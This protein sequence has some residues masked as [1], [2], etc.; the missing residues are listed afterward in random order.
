MFD[1][2]WS[3]TERESKAELPNCLLQLLCL[4]LWSSRG[5][6]TS[7]H[8]IR[9]SSSCLEPS[10]HH[11]S[12]KKLQ[13]FC[14][15]QPSSS[16]LESSREIIIHGFGSWNWTHLLTFCANSSPQIIPFWSRPAAGQF[17]YSRCPKKTQKFSQ[18]IEFLQIDFDFSQDFEQIA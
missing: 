6:P 5:N 15:A 1:V 11:F 16:F 7:S 9:H 3:F 2:V 12:E 18:N 4:C 10:C 14:S 13:L 17:S 8:K